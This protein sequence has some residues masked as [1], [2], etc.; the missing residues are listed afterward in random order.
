MGSVCASG[1]CLRQSYRLITIPGSVDISWSRRV[2]SFNHHGHKSI[3]IKSQFNLPRSPGRIPVGDRGRFDFRLSG[4]KIMRVVI[5][6]ANLTAPGDV[7]TA[8]DRYANRV[9][10][11]AALTWRIW[12][13]C[14]AHAGPTVKSIVRTYPERLSIAKGAHLR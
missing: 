6:R 7:H 13:H 4:D 10:K 12:R 11:R 1:H 2:R 8:W 14:G 9:R 3:S 5:R